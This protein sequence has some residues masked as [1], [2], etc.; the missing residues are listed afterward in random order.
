MVH[1]STLNDIFVPFETYFF[2]YYLFFWDFTLVPYDLI[3]V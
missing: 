2:T 3:P 1:I